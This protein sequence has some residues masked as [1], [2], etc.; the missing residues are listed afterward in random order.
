MVE[1]LLIFGMLAFIVVIHILYRR[2]MYNI[3]EKDGSPKEKRIAI[4]KA[5]LTLLAVFAIL[6]LIVQYVSTF[7]DT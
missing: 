3:A 4:A 5:T 6:F 7:I 2:M 1:I